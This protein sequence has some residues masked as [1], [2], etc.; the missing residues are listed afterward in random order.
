MVYVSLTDGNRLV[1][2][3][4][5]LPYTRYL[6]PGE[7]VKFEIVCTG[8]GESSSEDDIVVSATF[9]ENETDEVQTTEDK[10]TVVRV[11]FMPVLE[12]PTNPCIRRHKFGVREEISCA[13][14]PKLQGVEW[15]NVG[16]GMFDGAQYICSLD[17]DERP[18][19]VRYK[20]AEYTPL[21][22][23]VTPIDI[24]VKK[25]EHKTFGVPIN[26]AGGIGMK[27]ELLL[28]PL[29][30]CFSGIAVE[31]VPSDKGSREGYFAMPIFAELQSHTKNNGAGVWC[32][33]GGDNDFAT[34]VAAITNAI[35][36]ITPDGVLTDNVNFGWV[37][38]RVLWDIPMG[39]GEYES[40]E[41]DEPY[42]IFDN[43]KKSEMMIYNTGRSEVRKFGHH[44][45]RDINGD[46]Y[47]DNR[48]VE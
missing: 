45:T 8:Q 36:R 33:V 4:G 42:G 21:I 37:F 30:V 35:P 18:I 22:S 12:A 24:M 15:R 19:E 34:D 9:T 14:Q 25:V 40:S 23:V 48:K 29:D 39:W 11:D 28:K 31:E 7:S 44:V 1:K 13:C 26:H 20:D 3:G 16:N 41:H 2:R 47:L 17:V 46:I 5:S 43:S 10:L 32:K 6:D 38:G 27:F